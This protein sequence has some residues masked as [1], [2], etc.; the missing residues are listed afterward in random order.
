MKIASIGVGLFLLAFAILQSSP[1][2]A[3]AQVGVGELIEC[4]ESNPVTASFSTVATD[5]DDA[6]A[7]TFTLATS[8]TI[9]AVKVNAYKWTPSDGAMMTVSITGMSGGLPDLNTVHA[10]ET[11]DTSFL[12]VYDNGTP[13]NN[14]FSCL[15]TTDT[16]QLIVFDPPAILSSGTYAF[17]IEGVVGSV[18]NDSIIG[19]ELPAND[20]YAGGT[21]YECNVPTACTKL[22]PATW[23]LAGGTNHDISGMAWFDNVVVVAPINVDSW[24]VNFL[25]QLGLNSIFG[26]A[27]FASGIGLAVMLAIIIR[28][29]PP[30]IA[31]GIGGMFGVAFVGMTLISPEIFLTILALVGIAILFGI[32]RGF[33]GS[34]QVE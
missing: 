31:L 10:T 21:H 20:H 22:T 18:P 3:H 27:L 8:N 4:I 11:W 14:N 33:R 7:Q 16:A 30:L 23:D 12:D 19:F 17:V 6:E 5:N 15:S 32:V 26:K 1:N 28:K 13:S 29:G 25:E 9:S 34:G 2:V 24:I